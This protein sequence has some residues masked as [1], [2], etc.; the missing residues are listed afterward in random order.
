MELQPEFIYAAI[1]LPALFALSLIGEGI[2]KQM[3]HESGIVSLSMGIIFLAVIAGAF[4]A[5]VLNKV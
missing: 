2:H 4:F 3:R 5:L 1:I